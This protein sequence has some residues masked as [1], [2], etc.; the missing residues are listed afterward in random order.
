MASPLFFSFLVTHTK[1]GKNW[2]EATLYSCCNILLILPLK[3]AVLAR[4]FTGDIFAVI[5]SEASSLTEAQRFFWWHYYVLIRLIIEKK[6]FVSVRIA[7][8]WTLTSP[9]LKTS[10]RLAFLFIATLSFLRR[11]CKW[12]FHV[13]LNKQ[14]PL[15]CT[16]HSLWLIGNSTLQY[17]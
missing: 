2:E 5:P 4:S 17:Q 3:R 1:K 16:A 14:V 9:S 8:T 10:W 7:V 11:E 15:H 12:L 6:I 13:V